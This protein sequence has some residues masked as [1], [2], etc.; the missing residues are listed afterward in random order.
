MALEV[1]ILVAGAGPSGA[2]FASVLAPRYRVVLAD[3][4]ARPAPRIGESLIP[5]ARRLLRDMGLL[6]AFEAEPHAAYTGNRSFWGG[7]EEITDFI[8][9]PDGL[10]WH[11]DR[12]RFESFLRRAAQA[13]GATL[14]VPAHLTQPRRV[15][16]GF[17]VTAETPDGPQSI[18][19]RILVDATGRTATL[20]KSL[21]ARRHNTDRL[22]AHWIR[23]EDRAARDTGFS[24]IESAPNGWWYTAPVCTGGT[25]ARVLAY[26]TD[27]DQSAPPDLAAAAK[28]LPGL[29]PLL[30]RA[31]FEAISQTHTV[32]ANSAR[33]APFAGDGWLALGDAALSFDP[34]ASRG[35]F[36]ALYTALFGAMAVDD[37]LTGAQPDLTPYAAD[38]ARVADVYDGHLRHYYGADPRWRDHPFWQRRI[39]APAPA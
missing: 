28:A 24:T 36:S 25:P 7:A 30:R 33:L 35:V 29:G 32:P 19:A 5:A 9:D 16:D 17:E 23:G 13:R 20:A 22:V 21:G 10:G 2:A 31:G 26:H 34:L 1:D 3:R 18:R 37:L 6:Q 11:L 14:L 39:R 38:L 12:P 8:R 27:P 4:Q 15:G